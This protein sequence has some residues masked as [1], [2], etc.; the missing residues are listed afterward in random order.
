MWSIPENS[1]AKHYHFH[2]TIDRRILMRASKFY[3]A[4]NS[5]MSIALSLSLKGE[6]QLEPYSF[7]KNV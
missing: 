6:N 7:L 4:G 3:Y 5:L 2:T 1:Y